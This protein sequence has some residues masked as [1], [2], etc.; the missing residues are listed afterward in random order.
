M[1]RILA[2]LVVAWGMLLPV[3]HLAAEQLRVQPGVASSADARAVIEQYCVTCHS[4]R[5][6]AGGLS[7]QSLDLTDVSANSAPL[8]KVVRKLRLGA[9]PPVGLPRPPAQTYSALASWFETELDRAATSKV[10]SGRTETLHR[11]NRA[12]YQNAI[13]DLLH[14]EGVDIALMLP[15]DDASYGFDNIAG[16][17]GMSPTHLDRYLGAARKLSRI[18]VGDITMAPDGETHMIPPDLS[19]EDRLE[20]LPFGTRGG[21]RLRRYFPVDGEYVIRFQ[22]HT[23]TGISEKEDNYIELS[24]DGRQVFFEKMEQRPVAAT[25]NASDVRA[26]TDW[27]VRTLIKGGLRDLAVTFVKTTSAE[28]EDILR[29]YLRPPGVSSFRLTRMGGYRGPYVAQVSFLGPFNVTGVGDTPSRQRIF[30]C[31]PAND[32]E[33]T[34]CARKILSTLTR[35]AYRRPVTDAD[36]DRLMS[37]YSTGRTAGGFDHGI[38]MALD[39]LLA[40]PEFL[41]RIERDPANVAPGTTYPISDLELASRLSFFLWSSIP[42]DELLDAAANGTLRAPGGVERQVRRMLAD[43]KAEALVNNFVG[44]WLRLRNVPAT[45]P[46]NRLFPDYDET[47]RLAFRRETELL[48]SSIFLKE[49]RSVLDILDA[50]YTFVNERLARHYGIPNVYG[51]RFRRVTLADDNRRGL[52]GQGSI[53]TVTSQATRTSPVVRG[54]WILESLLGAPP[55]APPPNVPALEDTVLN[56][57]L[58]Q[59]ME[60]HRKNPVCAACHKMTDPLGFAL[61]NFD[62]VG[63]WRTEDA[64]LPVDSTGMLLDGTTFDGVVGL[65]TAL[66]GQASDMFVMTLT[67]RLMTYALGRGV[68]HDDMPALRT[69]TRAASRDGYRFSSLILNIVNSVPFQMRQSESPTA[70][71]TTAGR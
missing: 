13:R 62:A 46:N 65:R 2:A 64:G 51:S 61:E 52:L 25:G 16:I 49:D 68:D 59:R 69:I 58:R 47:L 4:D 43:P 38:Q 9:M 32:A 44:Q 19:Q 22:A 42:D 36:L 8:E 63:A 30:V 66:R 1:P 55:P 29:P 31:R 3:G 14:L 17:L 23:G 6:K 50:D 24:V 71:T 60:Q 57:T 70:V 7:L 34:P 20:D 18:A 10:H 54:K 53:L 48:A 35:R 39:R 11:L 45:A 40:S 27:E 33:E 41:F 37:F 21:T 56:G 67:E 15:T 5:A 26:D 28:A 12:E